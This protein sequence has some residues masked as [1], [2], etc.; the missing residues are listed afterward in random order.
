MRRAL[1]LFVIIVGAVLAL[2]LGTGS[3]ARP[4]DPPAAEEEAPGGGPPGFV[5]S[6]QARPPANYA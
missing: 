3:P 1:A 6:I 2:H 5:P 4:P